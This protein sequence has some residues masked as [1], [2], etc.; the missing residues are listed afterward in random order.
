MLSVM[1][2]KCTLITDLVL[3]LKYDMTKKWTQVFKGE[4]KYL[5]V[6]TWL[7]YMHAD[8]SVMNLDVSTNRKTL[9]LN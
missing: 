7:P 9:N 3:N 1:L 6:T 4:Q 2:N 5:Y 8:F